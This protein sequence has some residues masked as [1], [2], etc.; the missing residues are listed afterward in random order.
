MF[1]YVVNVPVHHGT[2]RIC[3]TVVVECL[4]ILTFPFTALRS[5]TC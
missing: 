2:Q 5:T 1:K 3:N 4:I